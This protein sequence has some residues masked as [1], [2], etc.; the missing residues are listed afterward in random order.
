MIGIR[1]A[2]T[3]AGSTR[4]RLLSSIAS[5]LNQGPAQTIVLNNLGE[6]RG[7]MWTYRRAESV[8]IDAS[9][10]GVFPL[11]ENIGA[12]EQEIARAK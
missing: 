12:S 1:N 9:P 4:A 6:L 10:N 7:A 3:T 2:R 8:G 11:N 5:K